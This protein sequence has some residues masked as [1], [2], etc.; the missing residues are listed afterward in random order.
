MGLELEWLLYHRADPTRPLS[1]ADLDLARH[2]G[3]VLT[4]GRLTVEPGGQLELSSEPFSDPAL[5]LRRIDADVSAFRAALQ[6]TGLELAGL[7]LDPHRP[8][9]RL[10][11]LPRYAA[12]ERYFDRG[13]PAGRTMMCSTA[14]VQINLDVGEDVAT[15][16]DLLHALVPVLIA[17][18]A[19]SPVATGPGRGTRS[20]RAAVWAAIDPARTRPARTDGAL[21]TADPRAA[22]AEYAL[23]APVLCIRTEGPDWS[24]PPGLTFREWLRGRGPRP[25]TLADLEY[26][27]TTLFPPVRPRGHLELRVVDAQRTEADAAAAL[28][29]AWVLCT[30]PTATDA[31]REALEPVPADPHVLARARRT[32]MA[33]TELAT[34][35]EGC[36]AAAIGAIDRLAAPGLRPV[37]ESFVAR[38]VERGRCPAD[39]TLDAWSAG[40]DLEAEIAGGE[41]PCPASRAS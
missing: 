15:R 3:D 6:P 39:D 9:N 19:N 31:A 22:W 13:G 38:Y 21:E 26:H 36:F 12:M 11:D 4:T 7:G 29:L 24:A 10:L 28:A 34:A 1:T 5:G 25:V 27:L 20:G 23:A 8:P 40:R 16:W 33:D 32:A 30:D 37:L 18:F 17:A 41:Q 2:A 14:A 35:A